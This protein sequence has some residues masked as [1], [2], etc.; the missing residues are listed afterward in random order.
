MRFKLDENLPSEMAELYAEAG[1]DTV[2]VLD[3]QM[4]GAED[5]DLAAICLSEDRILMTLDM[6]F[7][8]VRAYPPQHFPGIVV[9]RLSRQSRDHLLEI[10]AGLLLELTTSL[11][12]QLWIVE[13]SRIRV[14]E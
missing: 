8:D 12:G 2:T 3:Q 5:P 6:D 7:T 10:G 9:F 1:H 13:D 14:R 4:G 11:R